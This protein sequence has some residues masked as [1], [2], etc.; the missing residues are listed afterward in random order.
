MTQEQFNYIN[1]KLDKLV[2]LSEECR[3][4][5]INKGEYLIEFLTIP[6]IYVQ[7][8][9]KAILPSSDTTEPIALASLLYL[10]KTIKIQ[11]GAGAIELAERIEE[12]MELILK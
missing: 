11:M 4:G 8:I 1:K 6:N 5:T 9:K 2:K 12:L 3:S 10:T 7:E